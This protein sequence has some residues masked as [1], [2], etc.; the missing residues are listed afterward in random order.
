M[1]CL[2]RRAAQTEKHSL[3]Y[4]ILEPP[5]GMI[6]VLVTRNRSLLAAR[7]CFRDLLL[8][9][10]HST[11][12]LVYPQINSAINAFKN[13]ISLRRNSETHVTQYRVTFVKVF[14][15]LKLS[16]NHWKRSPMYVHIY[17][18]NVCGIFQRDSG[19][20]IENNSQAGVLPTIG[21]HV[22]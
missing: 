15:I 12:Q 10:L 7:G 9:K 20:V 22:N 4:S 2:P 3:C 16:S 13:H 5:R 21:K 17:T 8:T 1:H 19:A 14:N 18:V 6:H 11:R